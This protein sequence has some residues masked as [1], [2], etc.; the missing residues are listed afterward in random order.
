M[1]ET[2]HAEFSVPAFPLIGIAGPARAGKDTIGNFLKSAYGYELLGFADPLRRFAR[3]ICCLT[4][5][6][7]EAQKDK[8]IDWIGKS[9]RQMMQ[10][11]G[12]EWGRNMVNENLWILKAMTDAGADA[13][14]GIYTA[15][16]DVRFENEAEAIRGRG[17]YIIHVA[18][19]DALQVNAHV[20]EAGVQK[21]PRDFT[22]INDGSLTDLYAK[23]NEVME[24][25]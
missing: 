16:T 23:V 5:E 9:P 12:T 2:K 10:T 25:V 18:R 6:E 7:Y 19:P 14:D 11:L 15:I 21:H 24:N 1:Q 13:I 3:D 4:P 8:V 20:S 17:G 22:I